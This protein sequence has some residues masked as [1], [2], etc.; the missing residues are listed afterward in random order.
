M[1]IKGAV[2]RE[3]NKPLTIE[4]LELEPPGEGEVLVKYVRA[5]A[6]NK[7]T[8]L[9]RILVRMQGASASAYL[10]ICAGG[11]NTADGP[12]DKL[13]CVFIFFRGPKHGLLPFRSPLSAGRDG[14]TGALSLCC[15]P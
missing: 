13:D 1:K 7:C 8:R 11:C 10:W 6:K 15:G 14:R 5:S 2:L 12:K 4:T 3:A 9:R